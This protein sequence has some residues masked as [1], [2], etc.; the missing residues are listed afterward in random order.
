[1]N[2]ERAMIL[3]MLQ[4]GKLT[5]E[6]ADALLDVLKEDDETPSGFAGPEPG[7]A[8]SQ[9][10]RATAEHAAAGSTGRR[11]SGEQDAS[12]RTTGEQRRERSGS[13]AD[14]FRIGLDLSDL[15]IS[16]L[17]ETL[18][19]TMGS[20]RETVKGVSESLK[21]AFSEMGDADLAQHFTRAMGKVRA[22][23]EREVRAGTGAT[24]G[25]RVAN[26]WGDVR[27]TGADVDEIIARAKI[28][29]WAADSESAHGCI[30]DTDL[31]LEQQAG[32]WVLL[33][34]LGSDR[35]TRVDVDLTVPRAFDLTVSTGSGDLW[36]ED[37]S[38]SQ[39]VTTMSGDISVASLG[40]GPADRHHASTKSGD[41][42]AAELSGEVTLNTLS[43]DVAVNG[44]AGAL[45]VST[46]SGDIRVSAGRGS[47]ELQA[48]SGDISAE[49]EEPGGEG[50]RLTSVSG[51]SRLA[52]PTGT[53]LRV[54][55]KSVSGSAE[56]GLEL[57][58]A[59]RGE[60]RIR[61]VANGGAF[62]A[63]LSSV[64][65]DVSIRAR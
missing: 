19:T 8:P 31:R 32:E 10:D 16:G 11:A 59:V 14:G 46:K 26:K 48:V 15:D 53:S 34:S 37:L 33:T 63:V 51:D 23:D 50:I 49:I 62:P 40:S 12:D 65:G 56:V 41:I 39:T 27:V 2:D 60:H 52:V 38:G 44:F 9:A 5:V 54:D 4:E 43:G 22:S 28:T 3:K 47:V 58:D 7:G 64:S 55:L 1:M 45:R 21:E 17:Q 42:V 20:V 13:R 24:G 57:T 30:D 18:R 29:C 35:G 6:E 36:L 25:L 61:G